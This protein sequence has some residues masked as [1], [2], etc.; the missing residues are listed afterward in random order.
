MLT[1][2]NYYRSRGEVPSSSS[3]WE[4]QIKIIHKNE[5]WKS[6]MEDS[7]SKI[8]MARLKAEPP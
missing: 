8:K 1:D 7:S 3:S 4:F 5:N 2:R 6:E